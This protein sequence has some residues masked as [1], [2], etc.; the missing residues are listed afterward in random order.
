MKGN[1]GEWSELYTCINLL[2]IGK[3]YAADE[4]SN[5]INNI[6][7]PIIKI[8][9]NDIKDEEI[10]FELKDDS[11]INIFKNKKFLKDIKS[12]Q[13]K[14]YSEFLYN[15]IL[16]GKNRAFEINGIEDIMN[17]L[18]LKKIKSSPA[19][20][21][22]ISIMIHDVNTGYNPICNYS[23][24]SELGSA[25][26]LLN[27]S[28]AT[29]FVYQIGELPD[30]CFHF[31]NSISTK[32][33]IKDRLSA[34]L[35]NTNIAFLCAQNKIFSE[36]LMLIDSRMEEM[37]GHI[38]LKFYIDG[39]K[40]CK[41]IIKLLE[42]ENPMGFPR[43]GF[44]EYKFKKFLCS[45]ALGMFPSKQWDGIDDANGGYIIVK[46]NGDC[47]AYQLYN[48]NAFEEYLLNNTKLE[49]GSTSKHDY[50][51]LYKQSEKIFINLN[52]QIRFK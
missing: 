1:K 51:T 21:A 38:L 45:I 24:K 33:K 2:S 13:L 52:L 23:I 7:F 16:N 5:K 46:R 18:E 36:N 15:E 50:A 22:D 39:V 4:N 32:E 48:R 41:D 34:I 35:M 43:N 44:Y 31:I 3:L 26:T 25:P 12:E 17:S 9:R 47:L 6:F 30:K 42:K 28:K 40:D 49:K 8:I 10:E 20:K 29:N 37:I 11:Y 27:A 14:N 19:N